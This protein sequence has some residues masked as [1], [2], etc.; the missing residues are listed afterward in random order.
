MSA[1]HIE[2]NLQS[3]QLRSLLRSFIFFILFYLYLRL[4][5]GLSLI[6]HGGGKITNF[7]VFF[8]GWEFFRDFLSYPGGLV[9]YLSAFLSQFFYIGWTGALVVTIQAWLISEF[10]DYFFKAIN[11]PGSP[12]S[13]EQACPCGSRGWLR[14]VPPIIMLITYTQYTYHFLTIMAFL[15]AVFF[16][17]LYLTITQ[18]LTSNYSR[19]AVSL[20]LSVILYTI[21]GG[22][23]LLF[24]VLCAMYELFFRRRWLLGLLYLLSAVV[25]PYIEGVLVFGS[26]VIDAFSELLPFSWRIYFF[27][28]DKSMNII[29]CIL[30]LLLPLT[31]LALGL[32]QIFAKGR[33]LANATTEPKRRKKSKK[34][35]RSKSFKEL[36]AAVSSWYA[37][38]PVFKW[39]IESL[40]LFVIAGAAV[41]FSYDKERK[42]EFEVDYY[43]YHRMWPEVL[44]AAR[45]YPDNFFVIHAVNRALYRTGRLSY[46]MLSWPQHSDTLLLTAESQIATYLKKFDTFLDLGH[47]NLSE[48]ALTESLEKFGERPQILKRLALINMVKGRIGAARIYLQALRKTL[49]HADWADNYLARLRSD[50][51]LATDQRIQHLRSLMVSRDHIASLIKEDILL[52]LLQKNRQNKMAFEYLM[53][54]YMLTGKLDKFTENY[55]RL[56]DFDY[57]EI[58]RLY[59]EALLLYTVRTQKPFNLRGRQVS[60][61]SYGRFQVFNKVV[62][63]YKGNKN[64]ALNELVADFADSYFFY[65]LYQFMGSRK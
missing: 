45:R 1:I 53:A 59:E 6:Y 58:P 40:V 25:I 9:E 46:D 42:T 65:Y 60:Q 51:N 63:H 27:V 38:S 13:R 23:Y 26:S 36:A 11:F 5:V 33:N 3:K 62:N 48:N 28:T 21:A 29:V 47:I 22:A 49:F 8:K 30:Y 32:W 52:D 34:K 16:V 44:Q 18:P 37:R 15:T 17:C 12:L 41:F 19:V 24:A 39:I 10:I 56:D 43:A 64:A 57:T 14:F 55:Y 61:E 35:K 20:I 54:L 50:P 4:S 7:P 2:S 31:V